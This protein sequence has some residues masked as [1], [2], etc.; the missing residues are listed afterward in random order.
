MR[1]VPVLLLTF[2]PLPALADCGAGTEVFTCQ[3]GA[4][5][6]EICHVGDDLTYAFGPKGAPELTISE[7]LTTVNFAPWP[8]VSSNIWETVTFVNG[9]Y[10]YEVWTSVARD[11]EATDGQQGGVRV[12]NGEEM[13]A[14]L[15]CDPGTASNALDVIW[16]L[17]ESVGMCW[18]FSSIS[19]KTSCDNG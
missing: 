1:I 13:V 12:L 15:T 4:K 9:D 19:W 7:S 14:E 17:K 11:P 6:L 16:D 8:G 5:A 10:A 18:E 3:I 2:L